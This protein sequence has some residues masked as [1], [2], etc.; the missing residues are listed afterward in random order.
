MR[1]PYVSPTSA[2]SQYADRIGDFSV[3]DDQI[4]LDDA[5][6]SALGLGE[7]DASAFKDAATGVKDADD[8]IVYDSDT[9]ALAYDADGSGTAFGNVRFATITGSPVLTAADFVVV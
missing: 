5:I 6:F 9:G 7:L 1:V 3:A 8:R 4:E 2:H